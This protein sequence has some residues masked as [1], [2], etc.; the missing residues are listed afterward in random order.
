[1]TSGNRFFRT[2]TRLLSFKARVGKE[3]LVVSCVETAGGRPRERWFVS[4]FSRGSG[5]DLHIQIVGHRPTN[6]VL[7]VLNVA[8]DLSGIGVILQRHA[9]KFY[10]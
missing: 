9:D 8:I 10:E 4:Q 7:P 1:M 5:Y 2:A 6:P 3:N